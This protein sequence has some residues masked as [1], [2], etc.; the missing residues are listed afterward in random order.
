MS[1]CYLVVNEQFEPVLGILELQQALK[2]HG[3]KGGEL[4]N[5]DANHHQWVF[6]LLLEKHEHHIPDQGQMASI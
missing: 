6:T 3:D 2:E 4:L 5:E 1:S